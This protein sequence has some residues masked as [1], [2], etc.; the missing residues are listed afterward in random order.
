AV[1]F[2]ALSWVVSNVQAGPEAE[3]A[4]DLFLKDHVGN[5]KVQR[6]CAMLANAHSAT[7]E[8]FLRGVLEKSDKEKVQAQACLSLGQF[9]KN[10]ADQPGADPKVAKEA[11]EFLDRVVKKYAEAGKQLVDTAKAELFEVRNL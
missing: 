10:K 7:A 6:L 3:K 8:K 2:D 5:D 9:L 11:E 4:V 1:A